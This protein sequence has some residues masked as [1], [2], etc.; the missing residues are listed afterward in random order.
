MVNIG[1]EIGK[2]TKNAYGTT[3]DVAKGG[4]KFAY[5]FTPAG[6]AQAISGAFQ[7]NPLLLPM[8]FGGGALLLFV[9]LKSKP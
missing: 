6:T 9:F 8:L 1:K 4:F 7:Q 5:A 2:F 3:K